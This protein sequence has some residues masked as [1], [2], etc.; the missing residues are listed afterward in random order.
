MKY[1]F[2]TEEYWGKMIFLGLDQ[3]KFKL[4]PHHQDLDSIDTSSYQNIFFCGWSHDI[5][6]HMM[7]RNN[8]LEIHVFKNNKYKGESSLQHQILSGER[9][10]ALTILLSSGEKY[11]GDIVYQKEFDLDGDFEKIF[12]D[13]CKWGVIGVNSVLSDLNSEGLK[14]KPQ[15]ISF[16]SPLKKKRS[17]HEEVK[18]S[19]MLYFSSRDLYNKIRA[20]QDPY[21][22]AFFRMRDGSKIHLDSSYY[23]HTPESGS[24]RV[25]VLG[26]QGMLGHMV[27]KY[28]SQYHQ[29][30]TTDLRFP[31]EDFQDLI[32]KYTGDYIINC[33]GS[34]PQKSKDFSLNY[35]L[36]KFLERAAKSRVIHPATD[37]EMDD[38]EY[39]RSKRRAT[40]YILSYGK[41]SKVLQCSIIGPELNSH[42]SLLDWFLKNPSQ[43]VSG[44]TDAIWNGVT[45]LQWAKIAKEMIDL[46]DNFKRHN[47]VEGERISKFHLL[48]TIAE[49]F[50][51]DVTIRPVSGRGKDKTLS[52]D[53]KA[54]PIRNQLK[55]LIQFYYQ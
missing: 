10:S 37:C 32:L 29:I 44:Y 2:V 4:V 3:E 39:G 49:E 16:Y 26:H 38:D 34:I 19:D 13:I 52:G 48:F 27:V 1:L 23:E 22:K 9:K 41:K 43:Q 28:L 6:S 31:N 25:L 18:L 17:R 55:E 21:G 30:E 11:Q 46:W 24:K 35:E 33:A 54:P 42:K 40:E 47:V 5:P 14:R 20:F 15:D 36:P 45:T 50:R 8:C 12:S 7:E 51:K 53:L